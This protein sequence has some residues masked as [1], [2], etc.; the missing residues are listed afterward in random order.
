MSFGTVKEGGI[1]DI[2]KTTSTKIDKLV[3]AYNIYDLLKPFSSQFSLFF[4]QQTRPYLE[5]NHGIPLRTHAAL[6]LPQFE[7]RVLPR[8]TD[9]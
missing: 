7:E 4:T 8:N 5:A 9:M 2:V 1:R 3:A 6:L